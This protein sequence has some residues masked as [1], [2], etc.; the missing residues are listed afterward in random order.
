M[1]IV[2]ARSHPG[3]KPQHMTNLQRALVIAL[4]AAGLPL[5]AHAYVDP[6]TGMLV[7]QSLI[8][9]VGAFVVFVRNP[10]SALKRLIE[11]FKRK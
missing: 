5:T 11:R 6:G 2:W 3:R 9:V 1:E 4:L 7:W 10:A 8:A